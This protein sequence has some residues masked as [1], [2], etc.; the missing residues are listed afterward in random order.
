MTTKKAFFVI[1]YGREG[2]VTTTQWATKNV[3][4]KV[5]RDAARKDMTDWVEVVCDNHEIFT[6]VG[7][8]GPRRSLNEEGRRAHEFL[9]DHG[10]KK[11]G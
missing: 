11:H 1:V 10:I 6:E 2:E 7:A 4:V 8:Y 9:I 3:A 5:A